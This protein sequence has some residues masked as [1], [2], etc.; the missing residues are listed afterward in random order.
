[1]WIFHSLVSFWYRGSHTSASRGHVND[2]CV[3]VF[4]ITKECVTGGG[5]ALSPETPDRN[6]QCVSERDHNHVCFLYNFEQKWKC[7]RVCVCVCVVES[8]VCRLRST[9][10][11]LI[12]AGSDETK[13]GMLGRLE[14]REFVKWFSGADVFGSCF[15]HRVSLSW[16]SRETKPAAVDT[17]THTHTLPPYPHTTKT[18][19]HL[20]PNSP[21]AHDVN[22]SHTHTHTHTHTQVSQYWNEDWNYKLNHY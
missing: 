21:L 5:R 6:R 16:S 19:P 13:Q 1:M 17:H 10:H 11:L 15:P 2:V 22:P 7:V 20:N 8:R 4:S 9:E 12:P 14:C 18:N 3:C